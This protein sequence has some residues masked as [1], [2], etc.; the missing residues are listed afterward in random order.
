MWF[1]VI[2]TL[3]WFLYVRSAR[4]ILDPN[5]SPASILFLTCDICDEDQQVGS[6]S[7]P[8]DLTSADLD[9]EAWPSCVIG[10]G[11]VETMNCWLPPSG[12][13]PPCWYLQRWCC[14]HLKAAGTF[15]WDVNRWFLESSWC[16]QCIKKLN[17]GYSAQPFLVTEDTVFVWA[18]IYSD[19]FLSCS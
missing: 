1:S 9:C 5:P 17:L 3:M 13:R 12:L 15:S 2:P 8:E 6:C 11:Q 4:N 16:I 10:F 14:V 19:N 18:Q 7:P